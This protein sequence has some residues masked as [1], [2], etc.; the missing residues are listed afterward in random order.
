MVLGLCADDLGAPAL[1]RR[2]SLSFPLAMNQ[3][4]QLRPQVEAESRDAEAIR[5]VVVNEEQ[6][7]KIKQVGG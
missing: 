2:L 4:P 3:P 7:V 6:E 5:V 1:R